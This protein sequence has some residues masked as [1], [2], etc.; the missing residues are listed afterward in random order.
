MKTYAYLRCSTKLQSTDH[1][2][3]KIEAARVMVDE[4]RIE[5]AVSGSVRALDRPVFAELVGTVEAGDT[6]FAVSL[7]RLGRDTEDVLHTIRKF[8]EKGVHLRLMDLDGVDLTSPM[9]KMAITLLS[10]IA[11][12]ERD[13]C[14]ERSASGVA[15]ARAEG[16][17][18]GRYLKIAPD[19]FKAMC[20]RK[21]EG[22]TFE[23]LEKEFEVKRSSIHQVYTKWKDKLPEYVETYSKQQVQLVVKLEKAAQKQVKVGSN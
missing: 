15:A 14:I 7:D 4:W 1:Q 18:F 19:V 3:N 20:A 16:K 10:L 6:V 23:M 2:R 13:K 12:M 8:R 9:G 21:G 22:A 17:V 11:E 5:H